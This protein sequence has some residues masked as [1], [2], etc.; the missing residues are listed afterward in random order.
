MGGVTLV[1]MLMLD[2]TGFPSLTAWERGSLQAVQ[3]WPESERRTFIVVSVLVCCLYDDRDADRP[4]RVLWILR[5]DL[6]GGKVH[7]G[8]GRA[9]LEHIQ[10][11]GAS[12]SEATG[13][14]VVIN[15]L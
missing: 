4:T 6:C 8:N 3:N 13:V 15:P 2:L 14:M 5:W 12:L 10:S 11:S 9:T 7:C 1:L